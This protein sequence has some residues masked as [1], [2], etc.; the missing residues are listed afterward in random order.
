MRTVDFIWWRTD[1]AYEESHFGQL[2][3]KCEAF[4]VPWF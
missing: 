2:E 1:V 3:L 4:L